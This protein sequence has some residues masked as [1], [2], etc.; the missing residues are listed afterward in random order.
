MTSAGDPEVVIIDGHQLKLTNLD[1]VLYPEAG[2]TKRDVLEYYAAIADVLIP[3]AKDR[4]VTRKRWVDG[5]GTPDH[6]GEAF[7]QKNLDDSTPS[8]VTRRSITHKTRTN[9]YPLA[10]DLATLTWLGQTA[11][12]EIHV[13]QWRFGRNGQ[14]K[15]PDRLVLDLDPGDGVGVVEC[16]EVARYA[17]DILRAIGLD[18]V[19]VTSGSKGIHLYAALDGSQNSSAVSSVAHE[20][21]RALEADHPELVVSDM[22][23]S[24]RS[25]KVFVDWSQ[26]N[27]SKTTVTPYSLRGRFRP[28]VAAPRT[29]R[30]LA[31]TSLRQL[32]YR[33][34]VRRVKKRG[35]PLSELAVG[36]ISLGASHDRLATYRSK[37]HGSKTPEPIPET[38]SHAASGR[39]FVIQEHHARALHWDFR[40]EHNGVL[41]SWAL[42]KGPP[43][44]TTHNHL[45]VQTEDHPL[46]YGR[47]EGHIPQGEY[48]GG[49]V[50]IWDAGTYELVKWRDGEEIIATLHGKPDGGLGAPRTFALIH[51]GG[52]GKSAAN[53]LIHLMKDR[54]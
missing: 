14:P 34:V 44:D 6:P 32:E 35:D 39:S 47:F 13:P 38:A 8:W 16:A 50:S 52:D 3:H 7:F 49:D 11:T 24:I 42:P 53:W 9:V 27:A 33:E 31:S 21:A 5:V 36:R 54:R 18:S 2:T 40:L 41:V 17:R 15:N 1:K 37:R 28:T 19:P 26:N 29:W 30:E 43:T 46:E 10:G 48:G 51:T 23:K 22:K 4:P 45:A 12:L 25:G 20:L